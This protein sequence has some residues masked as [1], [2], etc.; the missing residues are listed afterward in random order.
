[1]APYDVNG[2]RDKDSNG[3]PDGT[4]TMLTGEILTDRERARMC[5][6]VQSVVEKTSLSDPLCAD[7]PAMCPED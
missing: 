1:M 4:P 6:L 5:W 7:K 2:P 3:L